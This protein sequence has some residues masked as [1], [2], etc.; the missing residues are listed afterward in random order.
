MACS[1]WSIRQCI[2]EAWPSRQI[3]ARD[4]VFIVDGLDVA[5]LKRSFEAFALD[6]HDGENLQSSRNSD[7]L[8]RQ[9]SS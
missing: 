4:I 9:S 7:L 8:E 3:G 6:R 1:T 2:M 5:L